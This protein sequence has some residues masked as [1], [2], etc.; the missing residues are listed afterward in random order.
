M[1]P[2]ETGFYVNQVRDLRENG[3]LDGEYI[4]FFYFNKDGIN[5]QKYKSLAK[6]LVLQIEAQI[7]DGFSSV[8]LV[9]KDVVQTNKKDYMV[10]VE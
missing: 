5:G 1:F 10:I 9:I 2:I 7:K 6:F 4:S 3:T 8:S